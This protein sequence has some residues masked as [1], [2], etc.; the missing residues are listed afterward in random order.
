MHTKM[1]LWHVCM[2]CMVALSLLWNQGLKSFPLQWAGVQGIN[3]GPQWE[4][5]QPG[6]TLQTVRSA[7]K[8]LR[9]KRSLLSKKKIKKPAFFLGERKVV[10][11]QKFWHWCSSC[12]KKKS[13]RSGH[14]SHHSFHTPCMC[15]I[16][17]L[18]MEMLVWKTSAHLYDVLMTDMD[19][20]S[21]SIETEYK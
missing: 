19:R 14:F 9:V 13:L 17:S 18:Q 6:V 4:Y 12:D 7:W 3:M 15:E 5:R 10:L 11:P 20:N 16:P 21:T 2:W 8:K 1:L